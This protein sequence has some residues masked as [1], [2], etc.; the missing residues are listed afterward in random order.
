MGGRLGF[1]EELF[2][3]YG[4]KR[5]QLRIGVEGI[6][7]NFTGVLGDGKVGVYFCKVG[8]GGGLERFLR[9]RRTISVWRFEQICS[10]IGVG[11]LGA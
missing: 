2:D 8:L 4:W 6:V 7:W 1:C 3:V 5:A 11:C 9:R 10:Q